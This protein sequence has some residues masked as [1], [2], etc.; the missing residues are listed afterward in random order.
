MKAA[1][2]VGRKYNRASVSTD[3]VS[4][5]YRGQKKKLKIKEINGS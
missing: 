5:I 3:S 1:E 4:A 2:T